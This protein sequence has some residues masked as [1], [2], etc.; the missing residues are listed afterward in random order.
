MDTKIIMLGTGNALVTHCYN[1]CFVLDNGHDK[2]LVD[3]GGGNGI[4]VQLER[5]GLDVGDVHHVFVTHAHTDHVLGIIWVV[6]SFIQRYMAGKVSGKLNIWSHNKVLQLLDFNLSQM[7]TPKQYAEI[8]HCVI[9]HEVQDRDE[10][11]CFSW[12]LQY[13]DILSTKE[14]QFGFCTVLDDGQ[15]LVCLGDEPYNEANKPLV[16]NAD[17]ILCEAF[18]KYGDRDTFHPY[19]KHHSTVKDAAELASTLGIKNII[20]YHTEDKT[21]ATRKEAYSAEAREYFSGGI[22]VPDDL[23]VITISKNIKQTIE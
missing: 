8:G 19:E 16:E 20:L 23:D 13:F 11:S 12:H 1:T 5:A 22:Y 14:K 17:W 21:I 9:F 6:R 7:L 4:L 10:F 18:C 2:I 15:R 3:A